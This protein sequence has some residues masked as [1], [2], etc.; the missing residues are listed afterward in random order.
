MDITDNEFDE[1]FQEAAAV[2]QFDKDMW[3]IASNSVMREKHWEPLSEVGL[4]QAVDNIAYEIFTRST[5]SVLCGEATEDHVQRHMEDIDKIGDIMF[6]VAVT[7][8]THIS[9]VNAMVSAN[10]IQRANKFVEIL[11]NR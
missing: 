1:V 6:M 3:T 2:T 5:A 11:A 8:K 4:A 10:I 7:S 9:I